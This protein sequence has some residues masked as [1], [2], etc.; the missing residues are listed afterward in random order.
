MILEAI[1]EAQKPRSKRFL[2]KNSM[3]TWQELIKKF[4]S[5]KFLLTLGAVLTALG[6]ALSGQIE[7][8]QAITA[9]V[10]AILGYVGVEGAADYERAKKPNQ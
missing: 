9:V 5:R 8:T 6:A 10:I 1:L 2:G 3:N 7:W 4:S